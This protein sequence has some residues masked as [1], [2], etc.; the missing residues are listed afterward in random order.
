[1]RTSPRS[2]QRVFQQ[3]F[4]VHDVARPL[5][6]FDDTT[7]TE[8]I[9][10]ILDARGDRIAGVRTDGVTTHF[11]TASELAAGRCSDFAHPI[12]DSQVVAD[13]LPLAQLVLRLKEQPDL[14]VESLGQIGGIV[15]RVDLHQPPARMWLFGMVTLLEMRFSRM[16]AR[17]CPNDSWRSYL[18]EG[19]IQKAEALLEERRRRNHQTTLADCLQFADKTRI[20]ARNQQLRSLT[21]F[22]SK[23]QIEDVGK[24]LELLRNNLAHSQDIIT[25]D[26]ETIVAL[27]ENLESVLDGPA[28]ARSDTS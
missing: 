8:Q 24:S 14:F 2:L 13:S 28:V 23:R 11:V 20:I 4:C 1:M 5:L 10:A 12:D 3:A 21:R 17:E 16:I 22:E 6:S 25:S 7:L 27:A 26:W 19:R 15:S 18:S 9:N